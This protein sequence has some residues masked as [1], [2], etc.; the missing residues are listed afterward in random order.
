MGCVIACLGSLVICDSPTYLGHFSPLDLVKK[1][2]QEG[3]S[4]PTVPP[5][6]SI[7]QFQSVGQMQLDHYRYLIGME[8]LDKNPI[9]LSFSMSSS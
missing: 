8:T 7:S 1:R 4:L 2:I 6:P 5:L 9:V 3:P